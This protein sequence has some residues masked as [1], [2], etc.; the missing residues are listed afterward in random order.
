[1]GVLSKIPFLS[2]VVGNNKQIP[3][4]NKLLIMLTIVEGAGGG[5]GRDS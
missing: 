5:K 2:F 4:R 1:M 3:F